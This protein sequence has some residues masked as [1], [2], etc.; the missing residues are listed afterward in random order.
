[1]DEVGRGPLAGP[2]VAAAVVFPPGTKPLRGLDD[3][4][5]L[6]AAAR[7]EIAVAIRA[8]A[9]AIGVGAAS[10]HEI[11]RL[12]IRRASILAM[13]RALDRLRCTPAYVLVDGLPCPELGVPHTAI[14]DGDARCQSIAAA[15]VIAK[16][17][18]DRLM[19]LLALRHPGYLWERNKGY[20]TTAHLAALD[21]HGLTAHHRLSFQ[22]VTQLV[23]L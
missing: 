7:A 15:S 17:V 23:L 6:T 14:I 2:V 9:L 13:R 11:D 18:R 20:S 8:R 22:P 16:T 5:R 12:N 4:K 21:A 3:S 1:M 19:Q 10:V